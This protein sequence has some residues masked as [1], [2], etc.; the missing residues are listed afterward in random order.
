[1]GSYDEII[2]FDYTNEKEWQKW[3]EERFLPLHKQ[4]SIISKLREHLEKKL[5]ENLEEAFKEQY[6]KEILLGGVTE[7]GEYAQESL[8]KAYKTTLGISINPRE[9]IAFCKI[10]LNPIKRGIKCNFEDTSF[11]TFINDLKNIIEEI[12]SKVGINPTIIEDREIESII[13][14][15]E[16]IIDVIRKIYEYT[17]SISANYD[18][19]MFFILNTRCTP[20]F[21]IKIA[22]PKLKDNFDKV[23]EILELEEKFTPNINDE[24]TKRYYTLIGHK[25]EGLA[26]IMFNIQ[27]TIW[28]HFNFSRGDFWDSE[29]WIDLKGIEE[30]FSKVLVP[31]DLWQEFKGK[32]KKIVAPLRRIE[33]ETANI[34][35]TGYN[36]ILYFVVINSL[37]IKAFNRYSPRYKKFY[38]E[39]FSIS[40]IDFIGKISPHAF[41]GVILIEPT[42][43]IPYPKVLSGI[44]NFDIILEF[45]NLLE[46]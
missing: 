44:G 28:S 29:E 6:I 13:N 16:E 12:F 25:K 41:T 9:W 35:I 45:H 5:T 37:V 31:K 1:M 30:V 2:G 19:H 20:R 42:E 36:K 27:H 38:N 40:F 24:K 22:Y 4:L 32:I 11:L 26:D 14:S 46:D 17:I 10:G 18:Y 15:P 21:F 39:N 43:E 33:F 8:A 23:A 7:E 34:D 3:I